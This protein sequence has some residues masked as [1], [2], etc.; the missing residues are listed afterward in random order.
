[1]AVTPEDVRRVRLATIETRV[2][3]LLKSENIPVDSEGKIH[4]RQNSL[5]SG[6]TLEI[7]E[8][9]YSGHWTVEL[10]A[11]AGEAKTFAF[12]PREK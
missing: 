6:T 1:M 5:P 11:P 9:I 4:I 10:V 7:L 8:Q 2:N 3:T 12:S